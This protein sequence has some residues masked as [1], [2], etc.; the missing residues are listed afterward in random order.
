MRLEDLKVGRG[1]EVYVIREGYR[2]RLGSKVE[3][4]D[5]G[6]VCISLIASGGRSFRFLDTDVVELVYHEG[7]YMWQWFK[8]KPTIEIYE[9]AKVHAFTSNEDGK[10]FNR[11]NSFRVDIAE[12]TILYRFVENN[13]NP[14]EKIAGEK[15]EV[16]DYGNEVGTV[17]V[18]EF[19]GYIKDLSESGVGIFTNS[20][21][22]VGDSIGFPLYTPFGVMYFK[23]T[24]VRHTVKRDTKYTEFYG[25]SF[26]RVDRNLG[27]YLVG[28]QRAQ[29]L[30][31]KGE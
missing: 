3:G 8:V 31:Q 27:R 23:A 5:K 20:I 9:G 6:K 7:A 25:C 1:I 19:E 11:R 4:T 17:K 16:D 24:V 10:I 30:R 22:Q 12:E 29:I 26:V 21:L 13:N 18:E 15:I 2:Y 14:K 28:I